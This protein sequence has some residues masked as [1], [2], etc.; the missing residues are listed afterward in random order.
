MLSPIQHTLLNIQ[1]PGIKALEPLKPLVLDAE[2]TH[3][4]QATGLVIFIHGSGSTRFS[5]RN[6]SVAKVFQQAGLST[7]LFNLLTAEEAQLDD[8][9]GEHRF[10][11]ALLTQRTVAVID[12]VQNHP[13]LDTLHIGLLGASTGAA[14]ALNAARLRPNEVECVVSRG[15]RPDLAMLS[16]PQVAAPT[17]LIVGALDTEV[18]ALNQRALNALPKRTPKQLCVI[19]GASHLLAEDDTLI[20]AAAMAGDWFVNYLRPLRG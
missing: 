10:N 3:L 5:P 14:A 8:I 17:L 12:W 4:P 15:G 2:L 6:Q 13:P 16:L 19:E 18:L 1:L 20:K 7:L 9:T 11:I